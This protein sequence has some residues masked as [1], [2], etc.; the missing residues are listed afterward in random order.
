MKY[1]TLFFL[2]AIATAALLFYGCLLGPEL[3]E[4]PCTVLLT[5]ENPIP[6][7]NV[8]VGDTLFVDLNNPPVFVS[9]ANR[10][11]SYHSSVR[12]R[13]KRVGLKLIADSNE[14]QSEELT[15]IQIVGQSVGRVSTEIT[16][17]SS[18]HEN[19]TTF[20]ITVTDP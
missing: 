16:A 2:I 17:S 12:Q 18:C 4:E 10:R 11:I 13:E 19:S 5:V 14:N 6:D 8:T 15:T 20:N 9:T 7:T 3:K 1:P